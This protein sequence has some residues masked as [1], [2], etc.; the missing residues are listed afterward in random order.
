MT[1]RDGNTEHPDYAALDLPDDKP[2]P[3]WGWQKRRAYIYG[4]WMDAGTHRLLNKS[5]LAEQFDVS[6]NT[7]YKDL[8][9]VAE[10]VDQNLGEHH[11]AETVGV[12][13][14]AVQ[15]LM[16]EGEYAR[17]AKVQTQMGD[18]LER[19][20]AIEKEPDRMEA[21]V[22]SADA[23]EVDEDDLEFLDEVF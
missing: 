15:E 4:E 12:L 14:R 11:G 13:K 1:D 19:R 22:A 18:W 3:E 9:S 21:K 23:S 2:Y 7:I 8:D 10:F 6:R 16:D 5:A 17:A 20:G